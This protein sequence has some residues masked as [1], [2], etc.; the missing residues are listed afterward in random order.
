MA[1]FREC[2]G[3]DSGARDAYRATCTFPS[4]PEST[5]I[6]SAI[7]KLTTAKAVLVATCTVTAA[8]GVAVAAGTG[9]LPNPAAAGGARP[10][11][12]TSAKSAHQ[13]D[14]GKDDKANKAEK[15]DKDKKR[16]GGPAG[17]QGSPSP[18]LVGLCHAVRSGNKTEH[19]KALQSPAFRH[20]ITTAGGMDK[21][22]A[23]CDA[24]LA[25]DQHGNKGGNGNGNGK[26]DVEG[27]DAGKPENPGNSDKPAKDDKSGKPVTDKTNNGHQPVEPRTGP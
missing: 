21:V 9:V 7:L 5:V 24:L 18:S 10:A 3:D 20:L 25:S 12:H 13:S 4:N 15:T 1:R 17:A 8:G 27:P 23:F 11:A 26:P 19:G 2:C 6:I 22:D 16:D 14:H